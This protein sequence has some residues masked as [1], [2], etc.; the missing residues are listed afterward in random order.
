MFDS[1]KYWNDRY[2]KGQNSG[3]GSYN[4]LAQFKADVIN[5]FLGRNQIKSIVDYGV[6]D[7]NQLKS[8]LGINSLNIKKRS[9]C[10]P[11]N[12]VKKGIF[13]FLNSLMSGNNFIISGRV[14]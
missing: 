10:C 13:S 2:V 8:G 4:K 7:G 3:A 11:V 1:K 6:G 12:K 9:L 5:D 14:P